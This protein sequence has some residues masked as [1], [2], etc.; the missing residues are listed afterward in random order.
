MYLFKHKLNLALEINI[1]FLHFCNQL[2][3]LVLIIHLI[4]FFIIRIKFN[5]YYE[6]III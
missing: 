1:F 4:L 3:C 6:F 2:M 5:S